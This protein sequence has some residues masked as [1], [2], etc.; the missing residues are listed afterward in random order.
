[1]F[2][3]DLGWSGGALLLGKLL[4]KCRGV[5]LIWIIE[6]QGFTVFTVAAGEVVW[7]SF[8]LSPVNGPIWIETL[9]QMA[10]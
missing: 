8:S 2:C 7:T 9:S 5:L 10:V 6:G 3:H 1:M 4:L